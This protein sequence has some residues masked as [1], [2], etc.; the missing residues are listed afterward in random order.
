M[1]GNQKLNRRGA[2]LKVMNRFENKSYSID[3]EFL[4]YCH[5]EDEWVEEDK[6]ECIEVFP[7][8]I[9]NK[10]DSPDVPFD[11]SINPYQGCE[12]GC[13]YC[14]ARGT[15]DFWGYE[16]GV[17]FERKILVKTNAPE[18]LEEKLKSKF[19]KVNPIMLSG[20]T[21]C[22][23]PIESRYKITRELLKLFL[24]YNHPV[25]IL[26]KNSLILR[27][28]DILKQ[29]AAKN[30]VHVG[31]S[32]TSMNDETRKVLEPRTSSVAK[33]FRVVKEL[34]RIGVPVNVMFAPVIPGINSH[35]MIPLL[36][37]SAALG[38]RSAAYIAVRLNGQNGVL[39]EDWLERNFK[40]KK[41]KVL[42]QI[43]ELHGGQLNDS[44]SKVRMKG[45][46]KLA[47]LL[48][49]QFKFA[50]RRFFKEE[51]KFEFDLS[52]YNRRRGEEGEVHKQLTLF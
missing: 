25:G 6:T 27:D 11:Y 50:K 40:N 41:D 46:G 51:A 16:S 26:T 15:H 44:R 39:F 1:A 37:K 43:K 5:Q 10:V 36:G 21:D 47:D 23:Q 30:L 24:K 7:K 29:L 12:H 34:S 28:A 9:I 14:Y 17:D 4:E 32:I 33:R 38:A 8:T 31:V 48:S 2:H 22:Y 45:E 35:E 18:L 19:W 3:G 20:N 42:N 13:I 52:L 49:T